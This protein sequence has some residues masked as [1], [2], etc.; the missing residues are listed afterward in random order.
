MDKPMKRL[1]L[2]VFL[3]MLPSLACGMF[4][5]TSKEQ[6]LE[7]T[8]A[9]LQ[10]EAAAK[11]SPEVST[12]VPTE[13]T[14]ETPMVETPGALT[15]TPKEE[16]SHLTLIG[17]L[18]GSA[19]AV[20]VDGHIAYLGQGPRLVTLDVSRPSEVTPL[21]MSEV[22]PGVVQ[23]VQV[24]GGYAYVTTR[25][26]GLHIF[27]IQDPARPTLVSSVQPD[28]PGC[29]GI[30]LRGDLAYLACNPGGL[31]IVDISN[32][33]QPRQVN[34]SRIAEPT[35]SI[36]LMGDFAY[37]VG[38]NQGL[39]AVD[40]SDP[41]HPQQKGVVSASDIP[42]AVPGPYFESVRAC[43]THL[44]LTVMNKGLVVL[45]VSNPAQPVVVGSYDAPSASGLASQGDWVYLVDDLNGVRV[46]D[47]TNPGQPSQV[48]LMPTSVG[49]FEFSVQ[50]TT[51]RGVLAAG[52]LLFVTDQTRG[53]V[54]VDV[55]QG[56]EPALVGHYQTPVPNVLFEIK[57][58]GSYA[59][60]AGR[61]S[62]FR[63]V[64]VSNP[65][66]P[67]E[68]YFDDRR[69][70]LYPQNPTGL[71]V[72][73]RYAY[74]SDANYPFHGYDISDP[75]KPVEVGAVYDHAASDGAFDLVVYGNFAYLSGWGLQD[76]FYP[77]KG[78]WVIDVSNPNQPKA[79]NFIDIPNER[80]RLALYDH[81]L[82]ALDGT[83]DEKQS[84]PF[85]LRVFDLAN[86]LQPVEVTK[87]PV[88]EMVPHFYSD[89]LADQGYL[90]V[91]IVP[92]TLLIF[93]LANPSQPVRVAAHTIMMGGY[94]NLEKEGNTLVL[95][96]VLTYD[97][98]D[99]MKPTMSGYTPLIREAWDYDM[100]GD[101]IYVATSGHGLYIFRY[102]P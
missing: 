59:Y 77:G 42:G 1:A 40:V 73:E 6:E 16:A 50:E 82:Y 71:V 2:I 9:F 70:D 36:A 85:A 75:R 21:G 14:G 89:I 29:N 44:C 65:A 86:P 45:D 35:I 22:L 101:L 79:A 99:I 47:L 64:D 15:P 30:A 74:L 55:S 60:L 24:A 41:S 66:Q 39:L 52:D 95:G 63:V 84:E 23:G 83:I 48:G 38:L 72:T 18:G 34:A 32:P 5:G 31:Y 7:S 62:G 94:T 12:L 91:N 69:K 46:L 97:V 25:Y 27:D 17:Q 10:T 8:I 81:Y 78:L 28:V 3:L 13:K 96:S 102:T 43:G 51:E 11:A 67:V 90:Y 49:G 76:A 33:Q 56:G 4:G 26:G 54:I 68:V 87:I 58:A 92:Q 80:W 37:L 98:S 57:V 20:A 53:L 61:D 19:F 88:P 100:V 93:D